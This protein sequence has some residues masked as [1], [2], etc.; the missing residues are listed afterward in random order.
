M[1]RIV[2]RAFKD[3]CKTYGRC[4]K[5]A[6]DLFALDEQRKVEVLFVPHASSELLLKAAKGCPYRAIGLFDE[7]T[8]EQTFPRQGGLMST[9]STD[10]LGETKP[11]GTRTS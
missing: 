7:S 6:P 9:V 8:G 1:N 4:L 3:K 5:V 10:N 11:D 2:P